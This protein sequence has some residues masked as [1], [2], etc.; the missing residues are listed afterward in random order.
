MGFHVKKPAKSHPSKTLFKA[1]SNTRQTRHKFDLANFGLCGV[2][3]LVI[4]LV[5]REFI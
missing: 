3:V 1:P 2:V 4:Y 5:L